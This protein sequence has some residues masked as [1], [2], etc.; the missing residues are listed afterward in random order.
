M[1]SIVSFVFF[2]V[3]ELIA[4]KIVHEKFLPFNHFF[5]G[6]M[7]AEL[8]CVLTA[9]STSFRCSL[10]GASSTYYWLVEL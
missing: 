2:R 4:A 9:D 8:A 1:V 5:S 3:R 7:W 10:L 6:K